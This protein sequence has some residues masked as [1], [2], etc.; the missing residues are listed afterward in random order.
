MSSNRDQV[1]NALVSQVV[2]YTQSAIGHISLRLIISVILT[3]V[4][5]ILCFRTTAPMINWLKERPISSVHL[6]LDS[7]WMSTQRWESCVLVAE[8]RWRR[9][10]LRCLVHVTRASW[11]IVLDSWQQASSR[12]AQTECTHLLEVHRAKQWASMD[13]CDKKRG[14][15]RRHHELLPLTCIDRSQGRDE[16]KEERGYHDQPKSRTDCRGPSYQGERGRCLSEV[17]P[18]TSCLQHCFGTDPA[19][20]W[21]DSRRNTVYIDQSVQQRSRRPWRVEEYQPYRRWKLSE[22]FWWPRNTP[23]ISFQRLDG[24]GA[25]S[26][27]KPSLSTGTVRSVATS[28]STVSASSISTAARGGVDNGSLASASRGRRIH[29]GL[30]EY[31][32]GNGSDWCVIAQSNTTSGLES[33]NHRQDCCGNA[34][35]N[36]E[37]KD[38]PVLTAS[39]VLQEQ[40][41]EIRQEDKVPEFAAAIRECGI[42]PR[43]RSS[44]VFWSPAKARDRSRE[45]NVL[46]RDTLLGGAT[47]RVKLDD[48]SHLKSWTILTSPIASITARGSKGTRLL[49]PTRRLSVLVGKSHRPDAKET[50]SDTI[51]V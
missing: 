8:V 42:W 50:S 41:F 10:A 23:P 19:L 36:D 20:P 26:G 3:C 13:V 5:A 40:P 39:H 46:S 34:R 27:G 49:S 21:M 51:A 32:H 47:K 18:L 6:L 1:N 12:I 11:Q 17:R 25:S 22:R 9:L 4:L 45:F 29:W 44:A 14:E 48:G 28:P 2:S 38:E 31:G 15:M 33:M 37:V 24:P 30:V 43:H 35:S 7:T 16:R